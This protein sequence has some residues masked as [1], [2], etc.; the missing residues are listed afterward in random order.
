MPFLLLDYKICFPSVPFS[1]SISVG[2]HLVLPAPR[3]LDGPRGRERDIGRRQKRE[4]KGTQARVCAGVSPFG[5]RSTVPDVG[6]L[7]CVR[8]SAHP[9]GRRRSPPLGP[10]RAGA[11]SAHSVTWVAMGLEP[12]PPNQKGWFPGLRCKPGLGPVEPDSSGDTRPGSEADR[13][14]VPEPPPHVLEVWPW[15]W[16]SSDAALALGL[17]ELRC[18]SGCLPGGMT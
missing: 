10:E 18:C 6:V 2:S 4:V 1:C 3:S 14:C 7:S 12:R 5:V 13:P 8:T 15:A 11:F 16:Q 9:V 17:A